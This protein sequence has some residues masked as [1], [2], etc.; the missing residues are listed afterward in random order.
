MTVRMEEQLKVMDRA[1]VD[2]AA[3]HVGG[4]W[5]DWVDMK[6]ARISLHG[7]KS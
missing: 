2:Q 1:G 4:V 6:A 5:L 7:D 3:L